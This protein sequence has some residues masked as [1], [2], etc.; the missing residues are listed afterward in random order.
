MPT[1]VL[2]GH[3]NTTPPQQLFPSSLNYLQDTIAWVGPKVLGTYLR[4]GQEYLSQPIYSFTRTYG[5]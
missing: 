4:E 2:W 3:H 1:I 5:P